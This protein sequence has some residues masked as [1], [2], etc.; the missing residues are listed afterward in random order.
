M[1]ELLN[2]LNAWW[3][4]FGTKDEI[5]QLAF[6]EETINH[7]LPENFGDNSGFGDAL[8]QVIGN[9]YEKNRAYERI[10]SFLEDFRVKQPALYQ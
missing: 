1:E 7:E 5:A 4:A 8:L 2:D 9:I 3:D 10:I 6:L